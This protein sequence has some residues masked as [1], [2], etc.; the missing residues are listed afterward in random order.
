M[1]ISDW[2]SDVCSSD[3]PQ[4]RHLVSSDFANGDPAGTTAP[5]ERASLLARSPFGDFWRPD[6]PPTTRATIMAV[7][8]V[9]T[10]F[11]VL[12]GLIIGDVLKI[13]RASCRERVC[14]YV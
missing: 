1:R 4:S 8:L 5:N 9:V 2:S 13:G 7:I 3:L 14:Q 6:R 10:V 12:A 11:L